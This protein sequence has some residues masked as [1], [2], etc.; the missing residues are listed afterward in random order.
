[1]V[2]SEIVNVVA[3]AAL[4]QK[5][6][7]TKF[8]DFREIRYDSTVYHGRVAYFKKANMQGRVSVFASGKMISVGT[9][10]EKNA[11]RELEYALK[12]LVK[13][14]FAQPAILDS[15]VRN[16]IV[17]ANLEN[18]V[19]LEKLSQ[20]P[21]AIYEPEQFPSVIL[22][23]ESPFKATILVF[24]SGKIVISGLTSS[25]QID[26]TIQQLQT[27]IAESAE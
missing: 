5:M 24:T 3:T 6:D 26:P 15:K 14:G 18:T 19:S 9:K 25:T 2:K 7:I 23:L 13:N 20:M 17:S 16:I 11:F 22:R 8:K 10:N 27:I 21:K 12:F 4:G 1:M